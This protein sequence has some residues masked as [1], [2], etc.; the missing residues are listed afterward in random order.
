[1]RILEL[2]Q[3]VSSKLFDGFEHAGARCLQACGRRFG[4]KVLVRRD[5]FGRLRSGVANQHE[6]FIKAIEHGRIGR[7]V[8][9]QAAFLRVLEG[10][11]GEL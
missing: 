1:M 8:C 4:G 10:A 6:G 3:V 9:R 5:E 2:C 7:R 11:R